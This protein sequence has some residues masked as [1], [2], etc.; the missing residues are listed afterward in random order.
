MPIKIETDEEYHAGEGVS[1]SRLFKALK[2]SPFHARYGKNENKP[3]FAIGKA[4]HIAILEPERLDASVLRG[5]DNRRGNDWKHAQN[6]A[7]HFG[8]ILLT[9]G[10]YDQAMLIRDLANTIPELDWLRSDPDNITETSAY[11][12]DE[13]TDLLLKTRVDFYSPRERI[14]VDVKN[15]ADGSPEGFRRDI[16]MF[17]YHMQDQLYSDVWEKGSGYKVDAFMFLVFE[18]CEPPTFKL[19]ELTPSS[20][21]EGYELYRNGVKLWA[22]C[23]AEN[24]FPSYGDGVQK[25]NLRRHDYKFTTPPADMSEEEED[26]DAEAEDQEGEDNGE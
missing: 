14:I 16:G 7:D 26:F 24:N 13:E 11:H 9:A 21:A 18:K 22:K 1:K 20:K 15:M 10:D 4:A 2:K 25:L 5:P 23:E 12:V 17:G 6:E 3:Q 19:Y 8:K